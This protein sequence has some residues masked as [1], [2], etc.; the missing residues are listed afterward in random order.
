MQEQSRLQKSFFNL[1]SGF[2]FRLISIFTAFVVR[3]VF[4]RCLNADYL[5]VNGLYSNILSMLS[6]T[7]LGFSTA[8]VFSMYKPLAEHDGEKL[9]QLMGLY[10]RIY[11]IIGTVILVLGLCLVPF[12]D[13]LIKDAPDI[14]GLT[15]YYLLFLSDTV[16]SYWFFAYRNSLLQADQR[17]HVLTSY[18][19]L[20]NIVKSALQIIVLLLFRNYTIYLL[21]QIGTTIGQNTATAFRV[22]K[23]YPQALTKNAS[24][25]PVNEQKKIFKDVRALM[26]QKISFVT[27]NST[28][29]ILISSLIGVSW[30]GLLSNFTIITEAVT[31]VLSQVSSAVSA[32]LGNY[33]AKESTDSGYMIF[34]R[35]EFLNFW[36]YGFSLIALITLLNPF[37]TL[38]LG[39][40]YAL[41]TFIVVSLAIRF[42]VEGYMN[43]MSIFRS[44]LGL[45]TFGQFLPLVVTVVNI[46]LSI[47]L[48]YPWGMAGILIATPISRLLVQAWYNPLIIHKFGFSRPVKPFYL[49]YLLRI[50][51][52]AG[53][54]F[55]TNEIVRYLL[56]DDITM[57]SFSLAVVIVAIFPNLIFLFVFHRS[58]EF[59]YFKDIFVKICCK[60]ISKFK[61]KSNK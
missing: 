25:L 44:T 56:L 53:T 41:S 42:F 24:K 33:F 23:D 59:Q 19:S 9:G 17:A 31:G 38:W 36:L 46:V 43:T 60:A 48:S 4:L 13:Y 61:S 35:M 21:I 3:T 14:S 40:K 5:G 18:Q 29:N 22:K 37:V 54:A 28:D 26:L 1:I 58:D 11:S 57:F 10:K 52:L 45:F 2:G 15:F 47:A 7:E 55:F 50:F 32:S 51:I 30:V 49:R 20:F 12:L 27:L 16:V 34:R 8:M 6:L 39:S